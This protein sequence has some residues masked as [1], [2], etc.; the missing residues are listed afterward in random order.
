MDE[1]SEFILS[2]VQI[3][4][5]LVPQSIRHPLLPLELNEYVLLLGWMEEFHDDLPLDLVTR[6]VSLLVCQDDYVT[7]VV[8]LDLASI[9]GQELQEFIITSI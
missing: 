7:T 5:N 1:A 8:G 9:L 3:E 4:I 2:V 6:L